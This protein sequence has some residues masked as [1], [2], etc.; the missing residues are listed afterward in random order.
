MGNLQK[1]VENVKPS[2]GRLLDSI[3]AALPTDDADY[4][5]HLL[6]D[7]DTPCSVISR[8][9]YQEGYVISERTL[10]KER[11]RLGS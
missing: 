8:A 10:Q 4:L 9:L 1:A 2:N 11:I 7:T 6:R 5:V 3:L